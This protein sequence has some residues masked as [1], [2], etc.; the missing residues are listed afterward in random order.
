MTHQEPCLF[1]GFLI[2]EKDDGVSGVASSASFTLYVNRDGPYLR[3]LRI[4]DSVYLGKYMTGIA[5]LE[6]LTL[7]ETNVY[8][9]L[10]KMAPGISYE[11]YPLYLFGVNNPHAH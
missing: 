11:K 3:T 6:T 5:T 10:K 1:I 4:G 9:I 7:L 8:S 2:N